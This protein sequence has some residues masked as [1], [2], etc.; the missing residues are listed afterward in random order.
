MSAGALDKIFDPFVQADSSVT[1]KFGGTGLGLAI[2]RKFARALG[3]DITVDSELGKGSSFQVRLTAGTVDGTDWINGEQAIEQLGELHSETTAGW[4]FPKARLLVVDDGP[5]NRELVKLVLQ[6]YG[7]SVDEAENGKVGVDLATANT[8]DVILMDVQMPVMDGFTATQKMRAQGIE[9]PIIALTAN[10]MKGFEKEC[11]DAGYSDYFTK[12]IDIDSFVAKLAEILDARPAELSRPEGADTDKPGGSSASPTATP[13][14]RSTFAGKDPQFEALAERFA[15]RLGGKLDEMALAWSALSYDA[16]ADL[17]HWLKGAGGTVGFDVLTK[18]AREL[19]SA[20]KSA[21]PGAVL[22]AMNT[23]WDIAA[24][25]PEVEVSRVPDA[26]PINA[27]A[28]RQGEANSPNSRAQDDIPGMAQD[29]SPIVS[30]LADNPRMHR[31]IDRF[32]DRLLNEGEAL[33]Q[34]WQADDMARITEVAQ[35]LKG[36]AGTLGFDVFTEP[37]QELEVYSKA[38]DKPA[39]E[40]LLSSICDMI[41]RVQHSPARADTQSETDTHDASVG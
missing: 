9:V 6:N 27:Q 7:L 26:T 4:A 12:P 20:A 16:L 15:T 17:A 41:M 39:L 30:R 36:S 22:E 37:S 24:Q 29:T 8:Y 21:D 25:I 23:L 5:E 13:A 32:V 1:R 10:A 40:P 31:L 2:S 19:E 3:G 11:L 28:T 38:G 34:A 33:T 14:I 18:P 35:W